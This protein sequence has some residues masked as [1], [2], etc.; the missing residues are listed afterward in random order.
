MQQMMTP[1]AASDVSTWDEE[2]DVVVV[3]YGIAGT[4]A[5]LAAREA[6]AEVVVLERGATPQGVCGRV[7]YL[8]GGTPM[9]EAMGVEDSPE[10]MHTFLRAA[11]GPGVDEAKLEAYCHGSVDHYKWLQNSGVAFV[12]GSDGDV[13]DLATPAKDGIRH[14]GGQEYVGGGLVWTGGEQAY[15]FNELARPAVR[16]HLPRDPEHPDVWVDAVTGRMRKTAERK[17]VRVMLDT[18]VQRLIL[19]EDDRVV[20]VE[21]Q[22]NGDTVRIRAFGGVVLATGGFIYNEE[23]LAAH[24]PHLLSTPKLG[25]EGQ[26]GLGIRM[27]SAI[28]ADVAHMD[29]S[30]ITLMMYPPVTFAKGILVNG[31]GQRFVNEDTYYGRLGAYAKY[32]ADGVLY[33][34]V[35]E[36]I[37]VDDWR[38]PTWESDS[39]AELEEQIGLP[40][41][42]LEH[43]VEYYNHH[44]ETG[45]DPILRKGSRWL[46]PLRPRYMVIDLREVRPEQEDDASVAAAPVPGADDTMVAMT[47]GGLRTD[48]DSRAL[49]ASGDP[50]EGLLAAGRASSG[51]GV[52]G[53][54]SGISL[55]DGSFFGRAAGR[56]AAQRAV[57]L[58]GAGR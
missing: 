24:A 7:I 45:E 55:G 37:Y 22:S 28:G 6:G 34:L 26:D 42:S 56:T 31:N 18:A 32:R 39:L 33:L 58:A 2:V 13:P 50:I 38:R 53:Y 41:G 27:A 48:V 29:T 36:S 49:R 25:H 11:L 21:A 35:D 46:Q 10:A 54:C 1:L 5:A 19:D 30:D 47:M 40:T 16:G 23:M 8:G 9:Q 44:A 20:G 12:E 3:G 4:A 43:T 57:E 52:Y 15:P 17:G 51:L 14:M